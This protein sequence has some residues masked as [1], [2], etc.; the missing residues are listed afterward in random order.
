[1]DRS[2]EKKPHGSRGAKA[3]RESYLLEITAGIIVR[4]SLFADEH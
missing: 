3:L 4:Y 1:M 2:P